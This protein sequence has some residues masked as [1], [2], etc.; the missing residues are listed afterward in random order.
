MEKVNMN[1]QPQGFDPV[2]FKETT[3]EQW[4]RV[5]EAWHRWGPTL[6]DLLGPVTETMLELTDVGAGDRVLDVA[7]GAGEPALSAA[8]RVG[9]TGYVLATDFSAN[10]LSFAAQLGREQGL[11]PTQFE[12]RVMDGE[13]LVL[14]DASFDVA[15]S[16]LGL[17]YFPDRLS[18]LAE[19]RR[20]L[21]PGGRVAIASFTTPE[22]NRFFSIPIG[23]IRRR[24]KLPPPPAGFPGPFSLGPKGVMEETLRKAGFRDIQTRTIRTP[25]RLPSTAECVRF[26]RESFGALQQMLVGLAEAERVAAWDEIERQLRQFQGQDSFETPAELIVGA[27]AK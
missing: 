2:Q 24:A 5:A 27:G 25:L 7:A 21:K 16:R 20:V 14:E 3:R 15:L 8:A 17:V 1:A 26:E 13:H 22:A 12:T 23:V 19:I 6:Q 18:A 9:P 11:G 10:L 4:E